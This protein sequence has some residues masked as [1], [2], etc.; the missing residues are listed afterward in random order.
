MRDAK[1][2]LTMTAGVWLPAAQALAGGSIG[3]VMVATIA[4]ANGADPWRWGAVGG[5]VAAG[6][7]WI[8]GV[9]RWRNSIS[10]PMGAL[11]HQAETINVHTTLDYGDGFMWGEFLDGLSVSREQ[12]ERLAAELVRD[13]EFTGARFGGKGKLLSRDEFEALRGRLV[14]AGFV[15][16]RSRGRTPGCELTHSGLAIMKRIAGSRQAQTH[17]SANE[18]SK[19]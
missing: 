15:R 14:A 5:S 13:P 19:W 7:A 9:I 10:A 4:W 2:F 16:W 1:V 11:T 12:F 17:K 18:S 8:G 6:L 3:F